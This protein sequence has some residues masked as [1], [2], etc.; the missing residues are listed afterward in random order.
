MIIP[1]G[2][3][4]H[5][6]GGGGGGIGHIDSESAQH[7]GLGKTHFKNNCAPDGP[8]IEPSTFGSSGLYALPIEPLRH[9]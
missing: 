4:T 8:G 2:A 5:G 6:R 1:V 9:P 7:F 3:Y